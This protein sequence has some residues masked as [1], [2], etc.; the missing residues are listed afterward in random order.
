MGAALKFKQP[1]VARQ[2]GE[3]ARL[4]VIRGPDAGS[5]YVIRGSHATIGRGE[6]NDVI[7]TDLKSSRQHAE[8]SLTPQGWTVID[9]GS[10]NGITCNGKP[11]RNG[12]L[13]TKDTLGLGETLFEFMS[14][15]AGTVMLRAPAASEQQVVNEQ[16]GYAVQKAKVLAMS[17][18]GGLAKNKPKLDAIKNLGGIERKI[19]IVQNSSAS[20]VEAKSDPKRLLIILAILGV[21]YMIMNGPAQTKVQQIKKD[22]KK[23]DSL[24]DQAS[25]SLLEPP[26][27][28]KTAEGFYKTGFREYRAGNFLR[29]RTQFETALQISPG[30]PLAKIYLD[31]ANQKIEEAIKDNL[32]LGKKALDAGKLKSARGYFEA[33]QRLLYRDPADPSFVQAKQMLEEVAKKEAS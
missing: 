29:A 20:K 21:G 16:A 30:H 26:A 15:D 8:L 4:K 6:E 9:N 1:Q 27:V 5:I 23:A 32:V 14:Q 25:S 12:V 13:K 11:A 19:E 24:A 31:N 3:I 33:V 10:A 17:Q 2:D 7:L 28:E 18:F 22:A